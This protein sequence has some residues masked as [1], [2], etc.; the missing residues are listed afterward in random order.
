MTDSAPTS[1]SALSRLAA[2][3]GPEKSRRGPPPVERWN[4]AY[5]GEIDMRIAADGTWH[6]MGTPINRP[7]LVRLFSTVLRKDPERYVLVTPVERVGITVEDAP[8][9]A[10]E[11]AV[12]GEGEAR[13]VAFRTNVDDLVQVGPDHPLRFETDAHGGVKPSVK[14]RG[15]LWARVTRALTFDLIALGEERMVEGVRQFGVPAG[16]VFFPIAPADEAQ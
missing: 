11:M 2:A 10:V 14:V 9:V 7:A 6:Y 13:Q 15:D 16:G 5:C 4:P 12:E 3:L 1:G 8:F